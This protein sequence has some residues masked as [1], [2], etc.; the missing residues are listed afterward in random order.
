[1]QNN[2]FLEQMVELERAINQATKTAEEMFSYI[3]HQDG[4]GADECT[5]WYN[6]M[7]CLEAMTAIKCTISVHAEEIK[8]ET[9]E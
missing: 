5:E 1:M 8:T 3:G 4:F 2:K 9:E 7:K 6:A